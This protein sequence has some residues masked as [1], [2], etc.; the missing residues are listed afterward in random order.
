MIIMLTVVATWALPVNAITSES[1][2]ED[3]YWRMSEC[4]VIQSFTLDE[5]LGQWGESAGFSFNWTMVSYSGFPNITP[6]ESPTGSVALSMTDRPRNYYTFDAF[7]S[8]IGVVSGEFTLTATG[9]VSSPTQVFFSQTDSR[10][11]WLTIPIDTNDDNTFEISYEFTLP[12]EEGQRGLRLLFTDNVD[13]TLDEFV[14]EGMGTTI[15]VQPPMFAP[16]DFIVD[17][18][19][20]R[21]SWSAVE[22]AEFYWFYV[23]GEYIGWVSDEYLYLSWII[24]SIITVVGGYERFYLQVTAARQGLHS[25]T[26]YGTPRSKPVEV[27][28]TIIETPVL[29]LVGR[30]LRWNTVSNADY[31]NI[32]LNG[33]SIR[34]SM[35]ANLLNVRIQSVLEFF[36][37]EPGIYNI[38]VRA[39]NDVGFSS[40]SNIIEFELE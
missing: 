21:V 35:P 20:G 8:D 39:V 22:G 7:F 40:I 37:V 24:D 36:E 1:E 34:A 6:V 2:L 31:L 15:P 30:Y 38:Q 19:T 25:D 10:W 28:I 17:S 18:E 26:F 23:N 3:I 29:R 12:L 11:E 32:Y 4:P 5:P 13:F 33:E 27:A 14:L 9:R 16:T